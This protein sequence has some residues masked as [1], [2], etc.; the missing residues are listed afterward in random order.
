MR[1]YILAE[2]NWKALKDSPMEVA[3]LPWGATEA[4]NFHLPYGTDNYEAD[5]LAAAAARYAWDRG[6]RVVVLP[7]I[8][9]G[10]NT[11]Q[12]DIYLDMNLNPST[13]LAILDDIAHT[14]HRQGIRKLVVF[15][16]H[17]GN[18]FKPLLRELGLR[19][20]NLFVCMT[21]WFRALNRDAR[22][23]APGDHADEVETSLMLHLQPGLV[24]PRTDWGSGKSRAFKIQG[25]RQGWA[26]AER[27]WSQA[28]VDTG[29][30]DPSRASA[31][32]GKAIADELTNTLGAFFLEL[33]HADPQDMYEQEAT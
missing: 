8:P 10:V 3:V 16:S 9:F 33:C 32:K 30:G 18:N 5:A 12:S 24:L 17:G 14:L 31:E 29:V 7:T 15:N 19:Y 13:Q 1:P 2:T 27:R 28:T 23:V 6:G 4:H 20:P 21:E 11:G 26:W 25:L 22:G